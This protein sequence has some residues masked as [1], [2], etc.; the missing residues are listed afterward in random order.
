MNP[1]LPGS[2]D[3]LLAVEQPIVLRAATVTLTLSKSSGRGTPCEEQ[4]YAAQ[5]PK[6][7]RYVKLSAAA[8]R[9]GLLSSSPAQRSEA[10]RQLLGGKRDNS[11]LF[12]STRELHKSVWGW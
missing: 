12:P 4:V 5:E 10:R 11:V 3:I 8:Y 9:K 1:G 7:N 6:V 2:R